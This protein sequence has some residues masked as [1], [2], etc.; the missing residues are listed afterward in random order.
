MSYDN[1]KIKLVKINNFSRKS[2]PKTK[3]NQRT[4]CI[5]KHETHFIVYFNN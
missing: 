2:N 3:N 1:S 4:I 5:S